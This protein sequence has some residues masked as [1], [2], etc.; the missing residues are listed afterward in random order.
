MD[1]DGSSSGEIFVPRRTGS[2]GGDENC[3][4]LW[5]EETKVDSRPGDTK[6]W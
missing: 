2:G 6:G 4:R 3:L 5:A 1:G